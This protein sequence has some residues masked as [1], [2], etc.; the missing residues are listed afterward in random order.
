[1]DNEADAKR[2]WKCI[3]F[4]VGFFQQT[5]IKLNEIKV[6]KQVL[7]LG[8]FMKSK[9]TIDL[10]WYNYRWITTLWK[11]PLRAPNA[12]YAA[13]GEDEWG[14]KEPLK[15]ASAA[16]LTQIKHPAFV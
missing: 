14:R 10:K 13:E 15:G 9:R 11:W 1:M 2:Q 16:A 7:K 5:N 12:L 4:W 6:E 8:T 3:G